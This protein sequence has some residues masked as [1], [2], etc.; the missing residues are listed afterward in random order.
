VLGATGFTGKLAA[1][2]LVTNYGALPSH[3]KWAIAGRSP[4]KVQSVAAQLK[5]TELPCLTADNDDLD[6][7]NKLAKQA[8]VIITTVGPYHVHGSKLVEAC[9]AAG[10]HLVDLTGESLWVHEARTT[11]FLL[12]QHLLAVFAVVLLPLLALLTRHS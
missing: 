7:L 2:Y 12:M 6:S 10:T 8:K 11:V 9:A 3:F 1:E 4:S 5:V